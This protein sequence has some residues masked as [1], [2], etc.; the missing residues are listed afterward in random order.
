VE[1]ETK[2]SKAERSHLKKSTVL[3]GLVLK[4]S[5]NEVTFFSDLK[6]RQ[7]YFIKNNVDW[8]EDGR[9]KQN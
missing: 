1:A 4:D 2:P 7:K 8:H 6:R 3:F 5:V 9:I